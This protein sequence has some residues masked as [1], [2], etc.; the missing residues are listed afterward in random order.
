MGK[1]KTILLPVQ[2]KTLRLL[3]ENIKL[4]RLRRELSSARI[5]ERAGISRTTLY[6]V[7]NGEDGVAIGI[8]LKVL[9]VLNLEGDLEK[10]ARDDKLGRALQDAKLLPKKRAPKKAKT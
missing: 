8:Y 1:P 4:A 2:Q 10:V 9:Y 6:K 3:G 5:S 7:E